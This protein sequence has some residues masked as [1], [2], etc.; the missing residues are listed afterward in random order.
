MHLAARR[1]HE[2]CTGERMSRRGDKGLSNDGGDAPSP[3]Q[4]KQF[5]LP[6]GPELS[7]WRCPGGGV[8][9]AVSW[10]RCLGGGVLVAVSWWR[11]PGGGV[12]AAVS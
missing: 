7:W 1:L 5:H 10:R 3:R 12:L 11:C 4:E 6:G 2:H 9:A 8:L